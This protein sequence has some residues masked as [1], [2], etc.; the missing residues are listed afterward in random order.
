VLDRGGGV[1][2]RLLVPFR[3]GL[4]A[5]LGD[6]SQYMSWI[7]RADEVAA[8]GFLL[9][10]PDISGP[11]N[12]T[13]PEPVTNAEFTA[14]LAEVL[15]RPGVLRV[16]AIALRAALGEAAG[17]LLAGARVQPVRL[18]AAGFQFRHPDIRMALAAILRSGTG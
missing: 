11:V 18:L 5:R 2:S 16:P 3:L 10:R 8:I 4:G 17:E 14:A 1:L 6:G 15:G 13:A 9:G 7:S 12:L